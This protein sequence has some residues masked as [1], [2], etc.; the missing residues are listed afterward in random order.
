M[1]TNSNADKKK[2]RDIKKGTC[3]S[4]SNKDKKLLACTRAAYFKEY[5]LK[6]NQNRTRAIPPA[7]TERLRQNQRKGDNTCLFVSVHNTLA[8]LFSNLPPECKTQLPLNFVENHLGV[9]SLLAAIVDGHKKLSE[10]LD[11]IKLDPKLCGSEK[12]GYTVGNTTH[13]ICVLFVLIN[14]YS[15]CSYFM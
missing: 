1:C 15:C 12:A 6:S 7:A 3:K 2:N 5:L 14:V 13:M 8:H 11:N 4:M 10:K 9:K